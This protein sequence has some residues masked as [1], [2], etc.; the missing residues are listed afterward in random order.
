LLD[1]APQESAGTERTDMDNPDK[2]GDPIMSDKATWTTHAI[3]KLWPSE[4]DTFRD[5]LLRLDP[6]SRRTRFAHSVS[7]AFIADYAARMSEMGSIVFGYFDDDHQLRATAE[8]RKLSASWS[9]DAEA[10]FTV[11][12]ALQEQGIGTALMG[13][14]IRSARN[15]GVQ[16]LY[17]SC[18]AE[19]ARMQRIARR[20]DAQLR[21]EFGEV[22][23]EIFP[24][25]ANYFSY[26]A[27]AVDDRVG[28]MLA[29]IDVTSRARAAA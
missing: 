6:E 23:G 11:E 27:E 14:L 22:V 28:Y 9:P 29:V 3:R 25:D 19:N 1:T 24:T 8:L 5:H 16:H 7:D 15:R 17:M 12:A 26:L 4:T 18:L 13:R 2:T 21:F 20:H 10:A